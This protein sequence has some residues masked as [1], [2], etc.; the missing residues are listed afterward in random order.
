VELWDEEPAGKLRIVIDIVVEK[1]GQ[2]AIVI[3]KGGAMLK[4]IGTE[5]RQEIERLIERPV[6]LELVV[7]VRED[8][9]QNPRML[10]DLGL[11]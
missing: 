8:W 4:Q 1:S 9:R 10:R 6:Y 2:K 3:G 5:A 7:K 11:G